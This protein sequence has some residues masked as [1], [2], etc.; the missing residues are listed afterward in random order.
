MN[1]GNDEKIR[2][3][4]KRAIPPVENRELQ[5]DLWPRMLRRLEHRPEPMP[6]LDWA[7]LGLLGGWRII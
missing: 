1:E 3:V 7:L 4:L 5:R 6:W 2:I